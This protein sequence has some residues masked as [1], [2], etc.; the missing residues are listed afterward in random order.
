MAQL[1][2]PIQTWELASSGAGTIVD[3]RTPGDFAMGHPS[4]ALSLAYSERGLGDR[5]SNVLP[6]GTPL[7]L[8]AATPEQG[9]AASA[10]LADSSFPL[11]GV[12]EGGTGSWQTAGLP[13]DSLPEV[14]VKE[15]GALTT[16]PD[17]VVLDVRE[18]KEWETGHVPGAML[19]SLGTLRQHIQ[20]IPRE[21]RITVICEA[22]VRSSTAASILQ[23][24]G[25]TDVAN[26]PE[27]TAGYRRAGVPLGYP[28]DSP[29]GGDDRS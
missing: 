26:V 29:L 21:A 6:P 10:Q 3:L 23:A 19:I 15:L 12:I 14:L 25:F 4:S 18:P 11:L 1:L 24:Q 5:L 13:V 9:E 28:D 2:A 22:G 16:S 20:S 8:L 17:L 7:I 27:G